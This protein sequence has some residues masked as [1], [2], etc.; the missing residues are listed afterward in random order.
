MGYSSI[1][2][3]YSEYI[4]AVETI[5]SNR[6]FSDGLMGFGKRE[7]SYSCHDEFYQKLNDEVL[8]ITKDMQSQSEVFDVIM[9]IFQAP[10]KNKNNT[11]VYWMMMAAH[12]LTENLFSI[13]SG[14]QAAELFRWY[15][16]T[17][18]HYERMP[19]QD[20]ML[21]VLKKRSTLE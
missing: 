18:P 11:S 19:N 1:E 14:N 9:F 12:S 7:D 8:A 10:I 20:K 16:H 17:Y 21:K 5:K 4:S 3:V 6:K 2:K 15:N 13:I